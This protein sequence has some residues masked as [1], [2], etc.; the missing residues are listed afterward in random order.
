MRKLLILLFCLTGVA[1]AQSDAN[2]FYA[3][4]DRAR[5]SR[6]PDDII[7]HYTEALKYTD[8][9]GDTD[10][11]FAYINRGTVYLNKEE[12]DIA[13]DDYT[14]A[15]E[16]NSSLI[17]AYFNRAVVYGLKGEDDAAIADY[18]TALEYE[19]DDVSIYYK[20]ANV[21]LDKEDYDAAIADFITAL[22]YRPNYEK[23]ID[24][25]EKARAA[26][27]GQ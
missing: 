5:A 10:I 20:R 11:A 27:A 25:M 19:P 13:I 21:Y 22:E 1:Y 12:Y 3:H 14:T 6:N 2:E 23:A 7:H 26:K 17:G 24:G 16:Y 4:F 15:L 18:T 8:G 9:V